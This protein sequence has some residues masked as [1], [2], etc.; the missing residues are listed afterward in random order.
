[1]KDYAVLLKP[2][3]V[4]TYLKERATAEPNDWYLNPMVDKLVKEYAAAKY[5]TEGSMRA[6]QIVEE[7]TDINELKKY[8]KKLIQSDMSVGLGIIKDDKRSK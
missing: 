5:D 7:M 2:D 6:S 1:L 8:L 4:R 3:D